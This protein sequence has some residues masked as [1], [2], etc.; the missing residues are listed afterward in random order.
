LEVG[1]AAYW[2]GDNNNGQLGIG[3]AAMFFAP[4]RV[5]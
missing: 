2:W 1:G 3:V 5:Q 4:V